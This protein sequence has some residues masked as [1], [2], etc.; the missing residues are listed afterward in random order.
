MF[1]VIIFP[2]NPELVAITFIKEFE[3]NP[4]KDMPS[5][6][7][8]SISGAIETSRIEFFCEFD[9]PSK[10]KIAKS[11]VNELRMPIK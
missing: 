8:K 5:T 6:Y 11:F 1:V 10:V 9:T 3:I 7:D 4:E 2:T